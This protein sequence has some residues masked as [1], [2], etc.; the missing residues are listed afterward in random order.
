MTKFVIVTLKRRIPIG[1]VMA[2]H[3]D[4]RNGFTYVSGIIQ[5]KFRQRGIGIEA[6]SI[7]VRYLNRGWNLRKIYY[8]VPQLVLE[9]VSGVWKDRLCIEGIL[10]QFTVYSGQLC[11]VW[12]LAQYGPLSPDLGAES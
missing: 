11:D 9:S 3:P 1:A 5:P 8:P 4:M 10:R 6:M 2:Y 7:F 12:M